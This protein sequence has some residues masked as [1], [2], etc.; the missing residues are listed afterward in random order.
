V[1]GEATSSD[2]ELDFRPGMEMRWEVTRSTEG[3]SGELFETINWLDP[4]LPGPPPHVHPESEESFEV[5]E[6][7]LDV[8]F[9]G[10]WRTLGPGASIT[11]PPGETHTL[12]NASDEPVK[13]YTRIRPAG[14]SE[15]FFR[16]MHRLIQEGKVRHLPPKEPRSAI[17]VAMLFGAYPDVIRTTKPPNGVFRTIALVGKALRF[18]L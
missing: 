7:S 15:A 13:T 1:P 2:R 3:T 9:D 11:V 5:I 18:K 12:R 10:E 17:Y 16:D 6:G 4:G 8:F 14:R